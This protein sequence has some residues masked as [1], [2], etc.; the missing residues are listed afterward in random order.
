M[1]NSSSIPFYGRPSGS[2]GL[3]ARDGSN[4]R[5]AL[6]NLIRRELKVGD[7]N[8]ASQVAQAL[9][10]RYQAAPRAQGIS[11]EAQGLPFLM[12]PAAP[13]ALVQAPTSSGAEWDQ[14]VSD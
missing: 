6:D 10:T 3:V 14:A 2:T 9:L 13:A 7:P 4:Q 11:Q 1:A 8:D 5:L 12:S